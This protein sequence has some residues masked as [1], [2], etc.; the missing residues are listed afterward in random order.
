M[1]PPKSDGDTDLL[2]VDVAVTE[3]GG[4]SILRLPP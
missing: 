2:E 1:F 4:D 3:F